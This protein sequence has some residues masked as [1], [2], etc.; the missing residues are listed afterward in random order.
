MSCLPADTF[1]H[2]E[3]R[4]SNFEQR[5]QEIL[6]RDAQIEAKRVQV[7]SQAAYG[8]G[9]VA[10]RH[11]NKKACETN[12]QMPRPQAWAGRNVHLPFY[13]LQATSLRGLAF[14]MG[15]GPAFH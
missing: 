11:P 4:I 3:Q 10:D 6:A 1:S 8:Y 13:L 2:F 12:R 7:I 5:E 14:L 9:L 15:G